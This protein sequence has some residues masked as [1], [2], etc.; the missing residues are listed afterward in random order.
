MISI[1]KKNIS[2]IYS[3]VHAYNTNYCTDLDKI[4]SYFVNFSSGVLCQL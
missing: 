3:E 2:M 4:G 1:H